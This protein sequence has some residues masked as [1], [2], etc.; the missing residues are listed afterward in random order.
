MVIV[1]GAHWYQPKY[2]DVIVMNQN[3]KMKVP[4]VFEDS[5]CQIL[6][7]LLDN[8]SKKEMSLECQEMY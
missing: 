5:L 7:L 3:G 8:K 4:M 6:T 1:H 2:C